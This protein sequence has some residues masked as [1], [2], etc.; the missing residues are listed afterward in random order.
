MEVREILEQVSRQKAE[1]IYNGHKPKYVFVD[2]NTYNKLKFASVM[3]NHEKDAFILK[4]YLGIDNDIDKLFGMLVIPLD[5][6]GFD[7]F[8]SVGI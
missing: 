3:Y 1:L 6:C 4:T 7:N 8:I 2:K 5:R